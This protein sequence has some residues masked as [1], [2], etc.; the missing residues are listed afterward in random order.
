MNRYSFLT[1]FFSKNGQAHRSEGASMSWI[2]VVSEDERFHRDVMRRLRNRSTVVGATG[3]AAARGLVR[4]INV[5]TLIVDAM[6]ECGRRFL[7]ALASA[8]RG[9]VG[10]IIAVGAKSS[11]SRF[12]AV[13]NVASIDLVG[14]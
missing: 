14:A 9:V 8:P 3:E 10:N 4:T 11:T 1:D 12:A 7:S 2:M 5:E 6:D 13:P